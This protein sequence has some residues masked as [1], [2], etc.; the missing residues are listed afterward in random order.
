MSNYGVVDIGFLLLGGIFGTGSFTMLALGIMAIR[1]RHRAQQTYVPVDAVV[2]SHRLRGDGGDTYEPRVEHS[3]PM[4]PS[5]RS[6]C[7]ID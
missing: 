5:M 4:C 3:R 1:S 6:S 2:V 7:R